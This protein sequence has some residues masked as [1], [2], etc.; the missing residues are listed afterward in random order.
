[1]T[2]KSQTA[3]PTCPRRRVVTIDCGYLHPEFAAA[4]LLI[5]Q[6]EGRPVTEARAAFVDNNT[7]HS[8]PR[9]LDALKR[10]GMTPAQV[11]F[12]IIT[13]VHLDHAGGTSLLM[14]ACPQAQCL[15]HPR[16]AKH[17]IDPTKLVQSAT[18]V[19]GEEPF[20]RMYGRIEPVEAA[21]VRLVED[22]ERIAWGSGAPLELMHTRGHANHHM[23]V[24]ER[25]TSSIFTGDAFGLAYPALQRRGLFVFPSTSP[26]DF[27]HGEAMRSVERIVASGAST[28]YPTH[29]GAVTELAAAAEQLR[30]DLD[31]S[32]GLVARGLGTG[33]PGSGSAGGGAL[34][35][36][37]LEAVFERELRERLRARAR[38]IGLELTAQDWE[39]LRL[40]LGLNAQG[41]AH[42]V[43]KGRRGG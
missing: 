11:D 30:E 33:G 43:R 24:L 32:Q 35:D 13:H 5:D 36:D 42:V 39:L 9:L 8:V 23:C 17:V 20:A 22:G 34:G 12:V 18:Q 1:L 28:A 3:D 21:R 41:L 27:D 6:P 25:E 2:L 19:Y 31:F 16:A 37:E 4:Y 15:A 26:T 38:R 10:E 29:F 7:A 14:K 40:D